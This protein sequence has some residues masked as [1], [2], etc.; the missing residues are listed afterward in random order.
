ME[1]E[2]NIRNVLHI[3]AGGGTGGIEVLCEEYA[4]KSKHK[5]V[6]LILWN[7]GVVSDEMRENGV[8]VVE[9]NAAKLGFVKTAREIEKTVKEYDIDTVVVHHGSPISHLHMQLVKMRHHDIRTVTYSHGLAGVMCRDEKKRGLTFRRAVL[10]WSLNKSD[11]IVAVSDIS[12]RSLIETFGADA[13]KIHVIYNGIE[14]K[15]YDTEKY[16]SRAAH[17]AAKPEV[18]YV[19]RLIEGKGV[20]ITLQA[21]ASV[22]DRLDFHFTV[23]GDGEYRGQLES[24]AARLGIDDKVTFMGSRRDVPRLLGRADVFVHVPTLEEGF[25]ITIVEA[26]AS[27]LVCICS[28]SGAIV[29]L[30]HDGVDGILVDKGDVSGTAAAIMRAAKMPDEERCGISRAAQLRSQD[31]SSDKF[32]TQLD[33]LID[34]ENLQAQNVD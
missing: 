10:K 5:N 16:E 33:A 18:I 14:L 27:G 3:L 21:L 29:E 20:Q 32:V 1:N 24:L 8:D 12:K 19:G 9:V 23:V 26:M 34:G 13:Q 25:G 22:G 2:I 17:N 15:D 11:I 4:Y 30:V 7:P 6:F 28:R 31:F